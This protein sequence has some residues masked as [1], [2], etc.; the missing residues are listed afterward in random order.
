M[1]KSVKVHTES[2]VREVTQ[3]YRIALKYK[4]LCRGHKNELM[5]PS[6]LLLFDNGFFTTVTGA[7]DMFH[8]FC[9]SK[10]LG[11]YTGHNYAVQK[12]T[13]YDYHTARIRYLP[14]D[15]AF[16]YHEYNV[17]QCESL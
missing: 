8:S 2:A 6:M 11:N 1:R 17:D 9:K 15:H 14:F 5:A 3:L 13:D 10:T 7:E 16:Y 4:E 12:P